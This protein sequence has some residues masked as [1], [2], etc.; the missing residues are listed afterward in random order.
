MDKLGVLLCGGPFSDNDFHS[1]YYNNTQIN[2]YNT[3]QRY[4]SSEI[5]VIIGYRL[6]RE[7]LQSLPNLALVHIPFAGVDILDLS[8]IKERG[9]PLS[10]SHTNAK[11]VAEFAVTLLFSLVKQIPKFDKD[12]RKG[13]WGGRWKKNILDD[14][15]GSTVTIL[16]FGS[17]GKE[18][19]YML[20]PFG[21]K[22]FAIKRS[23]RGDEEKYKD[24]V[25]EFGTKE[26]LI[27]FLGESDSLI[28]SVPLT[29]DTEGMVNYHVLDALGNGYL[30][31][32]SRGGVVN[33][34]DVF[35]YLK[36]KRLKGAALD[37]WWKYPKKGETVSYPSRF[38]FWELDNVIMTPHTAGVTHS[39]LEKT[40]EE[41]ISILKD[42]TYNRLPK[43]LVDLSKE[44]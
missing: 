21:I 20:K 18:I 23:L 3:S 22:V 8:M 11:A 40:K 29:K 16:G 37:V 13:I 26:D 9:I 12:L 4:D 38:P 31:N 25:Y 44:Y 35:N 36:D 14:L 33:E 1:F 17:I 32:I 43:N 6:T 28:I 15:Y 5:K 7:L 2:F 41:I 42:M 27:K 24:V 10:N 30:V 34:E 19:A 39:F